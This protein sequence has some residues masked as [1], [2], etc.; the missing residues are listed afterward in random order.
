[1]FF[2]RDDGRAATNLLRAR[3]GQFPG[4]GSTNS[5]RLANAENPIHAKVKCRPAGPT[6]PPHDGRQDTRGRCVRSFPRRPRHS[7]QQQNRRWATRE[8]ELGRVIPF[9]V[10]HQARCRSGSPR[11]GAGF[12][13]RI[14]RGQFFLESHE[15]E[16]E[17]RRLLLFR[18]PLCRFL[19]ADLQKKMCHNAAG[20]GP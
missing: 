6:V 20:P 15:A 12:L 14:C 5:Q 4:R 11:P 10:K 1:M 18:L 19:A 3:F 8:G 16:C 17:A 2:D 9:A 7:A 13:V